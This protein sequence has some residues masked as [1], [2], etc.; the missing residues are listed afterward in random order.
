MAGKDSTQ[1]WLDRNRPPRVQITYDVETGGASEKKELPMV[2][3]ILADLSGNLPDSKPAKMKERKFVE[4]DRD[5]RDTVMKRI[6]PR[7]KLDIVDAAGAKVDVDLKLESME[8]FDPA[9][10]VTKVESLD[11]LF[12]RRR[13]LNDMLAK[14]D[15]NE[16]LEA[17]LEKVIED[18]TF[19]DALKTQLEAEIKK[20]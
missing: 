5:N 11:S 16:A 17:A 8:D 9:R 6:G 7:V 18:K 14:L 20:L 15:G 2:M 3:G 13:A 4:I 10:L 1:H 19:L 12:K